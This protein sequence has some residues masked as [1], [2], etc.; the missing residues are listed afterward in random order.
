MKNNLN[1][2]EVSIAG[3]IVA[4]MIAAKIALSSLPNI[5]LVSFLIIIFTKKFGKK[6]LFVIPLYIVLEIIIF[7]FDV[8]WATASVYIWFIL[9]ITVRIFGKSESAVLLAVLSGMYG[10]VFG[11]LCSFPYIFVIT[12]TN[13]SAG[14]SSAFAYWIYG[15]PYDIIH[16]VSN[17]IV[18]IVLY[19]PVST[20]LNRINKE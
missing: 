1:A 20:L 3:I 16:G 12:G 6:M 14:F 7:G 15:I 18:M 8:M 10:L 9:Y 2:K 19:K 5:E 11:F 17:F 4:L 13:P